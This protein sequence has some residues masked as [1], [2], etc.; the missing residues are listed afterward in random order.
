M[1]LY[2][3]RNQESFAAVCKIAGAMLRALK[4]QEL[5]SFSNEQRSSAR[6]A[7]G[8]KDE[9]T[10]YLDYC[11]A[12][13][14]RYMD[15]PTL[16]DLR[17]AEAIFADHT[18]TT[19]RVLGNAHPKAVTYGRLLRG[20]R[21]RIVEARARESRAARGARETQPPR[22]FAKGWLDGPS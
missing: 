21:D 22:T 9:T 7:L 15:D 17:E 10:K 20:C 16:D 18:A 6:R 14:I 1:A 8:P 3:P 13:G 11:Y 5:K 19:Q 12:Y 4:Y 2:G